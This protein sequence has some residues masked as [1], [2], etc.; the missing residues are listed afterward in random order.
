[1][2]LEHTAVESGDGNPAE[3]RQQLRNQENKPEIVH[4]LPG[5]EEKRH[6][7]ED[8]A[9]QEGNQV[10][11]LLAQNCLI[12]AAENGI[13]QRRENTQRENADSG[14][15]IRKLQAFPHPEKRTCQRRK[16]SQKHCESQRNNARPKQ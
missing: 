7:V 1:M 14:C 8:K 6:K 12:I 16:R 9:A 4:S 13:D 2:K 5:A 3:K 10:G 15:G 11:K